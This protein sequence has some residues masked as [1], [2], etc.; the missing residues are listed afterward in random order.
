MT[1]FRS[2][3]AVSLAAVLV[4][5]PGAPASA[6]GSVPSEVAAYV[7]DGSLVAQLNDVYGVN[8]DGEGIDF[9][10]TTKPGVIERVH[11]WS[12]ELRAG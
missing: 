9:D 7:A 6:E 3:L 1:R 2:V 5:A 8:A 11:V 10:E 12:D 4:L